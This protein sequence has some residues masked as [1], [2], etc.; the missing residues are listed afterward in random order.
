[1]SAKRLLR[2]Q[3]K[4]ISAGKIVC[5]SATTLQGLCSQLL[6]VRTMLLKMFSAA[7]TYDFPTGRED[8]RRS[9]RGELDVAHQ[10]KTI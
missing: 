3:A 10:P 1:M 9:K 5:R 4:A 2:Q 7:V 6:R 8:N